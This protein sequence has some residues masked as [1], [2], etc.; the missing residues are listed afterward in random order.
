MTVEEHLNITDQAALARARAQRLGLTQDDIA[1]ALGLAQSQVSRLLAGRI[2][3][4]SR[5][6]DDLC[7]YLE[8]H[9]SSGSAEIAPELREAVLETWDGT[10]THAHS[11]AAVIRALSLLKPQRVEGAIDE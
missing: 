4:R 1:L 11:L 6:F 9:I 2:K 5:A 10:P 3:R 7:G 8:K